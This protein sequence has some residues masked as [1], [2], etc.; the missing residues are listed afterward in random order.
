MRETAPLGAALTASVEEATPEEEEEEEEEDEE[1]EEEEEG[2]PL[3]QPAV[4]RLICCTHFCLH[5]NCSVLTS[6]RQHNV[7]FL[8]SLC[9]F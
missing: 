4:L 7:L 1:G 5:L 2:D 6:A 9:C 3:C 8:A